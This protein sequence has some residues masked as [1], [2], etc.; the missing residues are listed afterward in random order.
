MREAE[1]STALYSIYL[2][3]GSSNNEGGYYWKVKCLLEKLEQGEGM[4]ESTGVLMVDAGLP[5][6]M[7]IVKNQENDLHRS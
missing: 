3:N 2:D 7:T 4:K 6:K 5:E 1:V